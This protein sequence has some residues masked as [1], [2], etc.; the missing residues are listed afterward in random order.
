MKLHLIRHGIRGKSTSDLDNPTYY[1]DAKIT[2][3]G[4]E[5]AKK[6]HDKIKH[7]I[8]INISISFN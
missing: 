2:S 4:K 7:K 1:Y 3:R 5:Q 8:L 6:L